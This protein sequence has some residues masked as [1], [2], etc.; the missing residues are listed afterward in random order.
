MIRERDQVIEVS[1]QVIEGRDQLS[2]LLDQMGE[3]SLQLEQ[4]P[5]QLERVLLQMEIL[6][7]G[8]SRKTRQ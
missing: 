6:D 7:L 3:R 4:A 8:F 1:L 5:D 2:G